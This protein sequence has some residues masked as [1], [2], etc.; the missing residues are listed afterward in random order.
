MFPA[1]AGMS[2]KHWCQ[3]WPSRNVPRAS[4]DEPM[5]ISRVQTCPGMF[6]ARAGMSL[7]F[8]AESQ[9]SV[10]VPRASGDEPARAVTPPTGPVCSPR[11]RG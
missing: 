9:D 11:E 10:N 5:V 3:R 4:G 8:F 2:R 1:R 7:L 6:P